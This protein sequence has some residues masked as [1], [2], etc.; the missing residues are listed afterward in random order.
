MNLYKSESGNYL[1]LICPSDHME[2]VLH[3]ICDAKAYFYTAL[4]ANFNWD[5]T[6][7]KN[8][9]NFIESRNILQIV[10]VT[11]Y[12]NHFYKKNIG[13]KNNT[14]LKV[15]RNLSSLERTLPNYFLNESHPILRNMLLASRHLGSQKKQLLETTSLG[16]TLKE[17][18]IHIKSF[19]YH[20]ENE[21]FY[22]PR[23]IEEKV[24]IHGKVSLN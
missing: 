14:I 10:F 17:H 3:Q 20:P 18:G 24:L 11:K 4:G 2:P 16:K 1:F 12:T 6:T 7:Q 22:S 19:V 23:I 8:L 5:D 9:I 13:T 15:H 21:A